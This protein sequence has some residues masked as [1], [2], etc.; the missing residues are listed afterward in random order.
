M[1]PRNNFIIFCALFLYSVV[2][3]AVGDEAALRPGDRVTFLGGTFVER[4]QIHGHFEA[5]IRSRLDGDVKFR[6][7]GWAGDNVLGESRAVFGAVEKGMERLLRDMELTDPTVIVVCYGGNEAHAGVA[8][9]NDFKANLTR[10]I[11]NLQPTGARFIF[12]APRPYENLGHP[13]PDP[14]TYNQKLV[15]YSQAIEAEATR[16][17][18]IFIDLARLKP[19]VSSKIIESSSEEGPWVIEDHGGLTSNGVHLTS[20]GYWRMASSFADALG[21]ERKQVQIDVVSKSAGA[22]CLTFDRNG[23]AMTIRGQIT[24]LPLAPIAS[25]SLDRATLRV[26]GLSSS[27][28]IVRSGEQL[29]GKFTRKELAAGVSINLPADVKRSQ[30]L[31]NAIIDKNMLFFHRH[32][33]QNETYLFLFRKHEQG[34]NAGEVPQFD[35]LVVNHDRRIYE[36]SQP[37]TFKITIIPA[38]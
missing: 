17:G 19:L 31:R 9:L 1:R 15:Q 12:V 5:E 25:T 32:R 24:Q 30:E 26:D 37:T 8:G 4:M 10:L 14:S 13:L 29:A 22:T 21:I 16:R 3:P 34:N 36:L 27:R 6:N 23:D 33:P 35:S 28:Y 18:S 7:L 2:A 11:D 38:K 20:Y